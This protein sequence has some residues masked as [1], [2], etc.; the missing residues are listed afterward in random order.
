MLQMVSP[1]KNL[2]NIGIPMQAMF[3]AADNVY[4]FLDTENEADN[5][6][7]TIKTA[8]GSIRFEHIDVRYPGQENK[9]LDDFTLYIRPGEKSP[10]SA[11]PEAGKP[12]LSTYCRAS[13][14]PNPAASRLTISTSVI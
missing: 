8:K 3:I 5:G 13:L 11:V 7:Q 6:T 2:S 10:W 9:A 4:A 1:I 14:R 12:R